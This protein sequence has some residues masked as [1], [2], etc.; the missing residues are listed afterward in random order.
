M[1]ISAIIATHNVDHVIIGKERLD[2]PG[3]IAKRLIGHQGLSTEDLPSTV[4]NTIARRFA[5]PFRRRLQW[6]VDVLHGIIQKKWLVVVHSFV[7]LQHLIELFREA[8]GRVGAIL[9]C[10]ELRILMQIQEAC[11]NLA[12][13]GTYNPTSVRPIVGP[14]VPIPIP[15]IQAA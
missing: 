4:R 8:K 12:I 11:P 1:R 15:F 3:D 10:I 7:S 14:T 5:Q 13:A 9:G 6:S 2:R